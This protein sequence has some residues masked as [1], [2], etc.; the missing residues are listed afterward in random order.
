MKI[1]ARILLKGSIK[2]VIKKAVNAE[3]V[4]V[5]QGGMSVAAIITN[6]SVDA[7]GARLGEAHASL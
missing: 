5:L 1:S 6:R 7:P 2:H 4:L 3:V